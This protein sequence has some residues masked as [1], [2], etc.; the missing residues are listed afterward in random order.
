MALFGSK[1]LKEDVLDSGRCIGCGA[2][3]DLC[4]YFKTHKGKTANLF[5]CTLE[6]GRCFA[7]CPKV[8]VDLEALSQ[9]IFSQS[10]D[11]SPL[12]A[13][14]SIQTAK[15]GPKAQ[16]GAC[17]SGGTVSALM[18]FALKQGVIDGAV[19]TDQK[20][21]LPTP[22]LVTE[23]GDVY[24]CAGS[25][26]A[27]APTL[28]EL[29][30]SVES[31]HRKI[32][33]V[34]TPCQTLAAAQ[35][36]SNPLKEA[37]FSDP[38][39][40]VVGLFCTWSLNYRSFEPFLSKIVP[41]ETIKK[42]DIPPPPAEVL[43]IHTASDKIEVPLDEIRRNVAD[44]CSYCPDM[45]SEFSDISVG[46]YEGQTDLNTLIIRTP[47]GA[48]LVAD[49]EETGYLV[50]GEMPRENLEHLVGAAENKKKKAMAKNSEEGLL[51]TTGDSKRSVFRFSEERNV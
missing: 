7:Y 17:Q 40:L 30:R 26:Y 33:L 21:I 1:E 23:P 38:L 39:A 48:K 41:I 46:V 35:I 42:I 51:N 8:E 45:T 9:Q 34:G 22:R 36:R 4:P 50:L 14:T 32:G 10:Y 11:G 3:I 18:D 15:A 37:D 44:S 2:C 13:Y 20:G 25:K 49:A 6:G 28:S 5:P 47:M 16:G 29:N 43:E 27:S 24:E 19:L 31:G 12:G